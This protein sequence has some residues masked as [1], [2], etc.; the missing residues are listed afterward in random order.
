MSAKPARTAMLKLAGVETSASVGLLLADPP[1]AHKAA[2]PRGKPPVRDTTRVERKSR[3]RIERNNHR[4]DMRY[5]V[6]HLLSARAADGDIEGTILR[7]CGALR[8]LMGWDE[9]TFWP[10]YG[11]VGALRLAP[12]SG[13]S[14]RAVA[15]TTTNARH[16]PVPLVSRFAAVSHVLVTGA[17]T[18]LIDGAYGSTTDD[19]AQAMASGGRSTFVFPVRGASDLL[20]AI[21]CLS[22]TPRTPDMTRLEEAAAVGTI[23]GQ[24]IERQREHGA[25]QPLGP[26][27]G[28]AM[29]RAIL[30]LSSDDA[31]QLDTAF[32]ALT[33][34]VLIFDHEGRI[35]HANAA[36][37][38]ML[39]YSVD[40][41]DITTSLRERGQVM[42]LRDP[43][44][45]PI[46]GDQS[47][48]ER[49][50]RGET[51]NG[52]QTMDARLRTLDGRDIEVNISSA[53]FVD[54]AGRLDGGIVVTRDVTEQRAHERN[55]QSTIRLMQEFLAIAAHELK[56]PITASKAY[57]QL[58]ARGMNRL[59]GM[60]T[61]EAPAL[62]GS[63]QH[64][65][66]NLFDA[67]RSAERLARL[68]ERLLDVAHI[69]TN[70]LELRVEAVDLAAI[71]HARVRE[72]RL[73]TP[74]RAIRYKVRPIRAVPSL[75][76]PDRIG[77][78]LLNY[79]ANALK[80]SP[81][82]GVVEVT[83]DVRDAVARVSVR[84]AGLGIPAAEQERIWTRFEQLGS[85]QQPGASSGLGLGLYISRALVEAHGG[86]VGVDS[87]IG[88]GST[89]W[90]DVPLAP[91]SD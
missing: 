3:R 87:A 20:G 63:I 68:I 50:L 28:L 24:F 6:N 67:E 75:V 9:V 26:H 21:E 86:H 1:H 2:K 84:D 4:V 46:T 32:D 42:I 91:H 53:P 34:S 70:K 72:Q 52:Q 78:V 16:M 90:F 22:A 38:A 23:M 5:I 66:K 55:L 58:A 39:G 83:L 18:Y 89:F 45:Q 14:A 49:I 88:Q 77:Q 61:T 37:R 43:Q 80:Y 35:L 7:V 29:E 17:S 25:S 19:T 12:G 13:I 54:A 71:I 85:T 56:T 33:D 44:G 79:L 15:V 81:E 36:D 73:A 11:E 30:M 40:T 60:A 82:D 47:P 10:A 27:A 59:E 65:L 31:R 48:F 8:D 51:L 57:V 76:D 74:A 62:V 41:S 64:M 69:Q